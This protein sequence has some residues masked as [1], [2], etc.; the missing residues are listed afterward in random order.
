MHALGCFA[1]K[2]MGNLGKF[3]ASS[4]SPPLHQ[5]LLLFL[6]CTTV[7]VSVGFQSAATAGKRRT[8]RDKYDLKPLHVSPNECYNEAVILSPSS[9]VSLTGIIS[10]NDFP[11]TVSI[12]SSASSGNNWVHEAVHLLQERGVCVLETRD[13]APIPASICQETDQAA[14][15]R[16]EA[17]LFKHDQ[18]QE[19]KEQ[20]QFRFLEVV[21]RDAGGNRYDM[22]MP[23][24]HHAN[25]NYT[26][27][28]LTNSESQAMIQFQEQMEAVV[29][30]VMDALW[31]N[32]N[33]NNGENNYDNDNGVDRNLHGQVISCGFLINRPGSLD[34]LWHRDG[35]SEGLINVFIPLVDLTPEIGPTQVWS[36]THLAPSLPASS[37]NGNDDNRDNDDRSIAPSSSRKGAPMMKAGQILMMDYRTFHRGMGNTSPDTTRTVA[38]VVYHRGNISLGD[39]L[40]YGLLPSVYPSIGGDKSQVLDNNHKHHL[41]L[42]SN[43]AAAPKILH[44]EFS[45]TMSADADEWAQAAA[46]KLHNHGIC[47]LRHA[48][49]KE[50][51]HPYLCCE[52]VNEIVASRLTQ[53]QLKIANRGMDPTGE[54]EPFRFLEISCRDDTGLRYDMPLSWKNQHAIGTPL[55]EEESSGIIQLH[56]QMEHLVEPV[57]THLW[58]KYDSSSSYHVAA[59][60]FHVDKPGANHVPWHR[61]GCEEGS[62]HAFCP[63]VDLAKDLGPTELWPNSHSAAA[64]AA[65]SSA[66][67]SDKMDPVLRAGDMLLVDDRTLRQFLG[68]QSPITTR[69]IA[70]A[71][72]RKGKSSLSG[73]LRDN[74]NN[75]QGALTL[76]YD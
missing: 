24:K 59:S 46:Q 17:L 14:K 43:Y 11:F 47:V 22:P 9:S 3:N 72:F 15:S 4:S 30:P 63:M 18:K 71:V 66:E 53:L 31:N 50:K 51:E 19:K 39:K 40:S 8:S 75:L 27:I 54:E 45:Q 62:I 16:L 52:N 25:K 74:T 67:A 2:E 12:P 69:A 60:G 57:L 49:T 73:G 13:N 38:Y 35:P 58:D 37:S 28:P 55:S 68:N 34:Q 7:N 32:G 21:S 26:G 29:Q 56:T 44:T 1:G 42:N 61:D 6:L 41:H 36:N 10:K 23:W 5:V 70:Y 65:S 76:E 33:Y 20:Q 64:A 48:T